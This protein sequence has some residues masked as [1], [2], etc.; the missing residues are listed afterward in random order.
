[1]GKPQKKTVEALKLWLDGR[2]EGPNG[3]T[4]PSFQGLSATR[5]NDKADL[6]ALHQEF[7]RDWL[8]RLVEI[9]YLRL[10]CL[11][12]KGPS[13]SANVDKIDTLSTASRT[14]M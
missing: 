4:A 12:S 6:V 10:F 1:M 5:L 2:S 14:L 13:M 8:A 7:E 3:R 11:V 9:P